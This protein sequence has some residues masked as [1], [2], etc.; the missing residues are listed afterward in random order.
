MGDARL[1][2]ITCEVH[3]LCLWFLNKYIGNCETP[4]F[5]NLVVQYRQYHKQGAL[6][7]L[8]LR[9]RILAP[10]VPL[11]ATS[12]ESVPSVDIVNIVQRNSA[13]TEFRNSY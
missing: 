11:R 7:P 5:Q 1:R 4:Y 2:R 9:C 6:E 10:Y 12:S 13:K 8:V 3:I